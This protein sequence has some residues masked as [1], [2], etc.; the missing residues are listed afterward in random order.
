MCKKKNFHRINKQ[1]KGIRTD[2]K[3]CKMCLKT[4]F[5]AH[6]PPFD[7]GSNTLA[8]FLDS[9]KGAFFLHTPVWLGVVMVIC[10]HES[11]Y[12]H[13]SIFGSFWRGGVEVSRQQI[14]PKIY[15]P[16]LRFSF[17]IKTDPEMI[18]TRNKISFY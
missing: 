6:F 13:I 16:I 5:L 18:P 4:M 8:L 9:V 2:V 12:F 1:S 14:K 10:Y 3:R 11:S 15:E 7:I 17:H